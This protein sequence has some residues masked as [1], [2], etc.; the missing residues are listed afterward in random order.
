MATARAAVRTIDW[1]KLTVSL[2]KET[3]A[4]LQAFRKRNDEARRI[5][6]D[7][8]QQRTDVDFEHYRKALK[9]QNIVEDAQKA[10]TGFKPTTYNIDAQLKAIDQF[11]AKAVSKA[12]STVQQIDAELKDLN[13]TLAN[14]EQSRPIESLTVDDII[15]AKPEIIQDVEKSLEKGQFSVPG[16]KEKFG[17]ISYF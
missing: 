7:L 17:D 15:A 14:I 10:L 8:K 9:N 16:Y 6:D 2:P 12:E 4:S 3:V 13:A 11:E 5:L 1:S